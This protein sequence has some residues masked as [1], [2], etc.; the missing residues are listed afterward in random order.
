MKQLI[1]GNLNGWRI[2]QSLPQPYIPWT[3][4]RVPWKAQQQG[5]GVYGLERNLTAKYTVDC[6]EM[7]QGDMREKTAVVNAFGR[8]LGNDGVKAI[9]LSHSQGVEPSP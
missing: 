7:A 8:N 5:T 6:K 3:R 9:L 4:K 1:G 2:R